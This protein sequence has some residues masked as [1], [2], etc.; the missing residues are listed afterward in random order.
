MT[1]C[2]IDN[3]LNCTLNFDAVVCMLYVC[4]SVCLYV[5]VCVCQL[6]TCMIT[7]VVS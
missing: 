7:S 4:M 1:C 2:Y 6:P 3:A 5:C